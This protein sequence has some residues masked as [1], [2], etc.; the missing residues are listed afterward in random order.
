MNDCVFIDKAGF[1]RNMRRSYGWCEVRTPCKI[2]VETRESN[3]S[4]LGA[5]FKDGQ[6]TLSRKEIITTPAAGK[7]Q[8]A[9]DT[10]AVK[11]KGI[12]NNDFLEFIEQVLTTIDVAGMNYNYVVLENASIHKANLVRDWVEQRG[13]R[14]FFLPSYS[15]FLNPIEEF[16]S[17]LKNV[18]N[19]DPTSVRQGTK[20]SKKKKKKKKSCEIWIRHPLSLWQRCI[21]LRKRVV[22]K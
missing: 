10:P 2:K 9:D 6:I 21:L 14:L 7:R 19:N 13:Y 4:I 16:G 1:N 12:T 20:V 11:R 8:R 17:K 5:I 3:V 15:P 18:V 22:K